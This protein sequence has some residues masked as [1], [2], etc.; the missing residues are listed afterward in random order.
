MMGTILFLIVI[1]GL[2]WLMPDEHHRKIHEDEG[3]SIHKPRD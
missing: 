2:F 1:G 3:Y